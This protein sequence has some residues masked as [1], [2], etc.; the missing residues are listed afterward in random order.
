MLKE[1]VS[2]RMQ[3]MTPGQRLVAGYILDSPHEA[4]FLT[5]SQLGRSV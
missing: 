2:A 3:Q 5:A 4:A 1:L